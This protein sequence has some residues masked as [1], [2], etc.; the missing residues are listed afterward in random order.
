MFFGSLAGCAAVTAT[1]LMVTVWLVC[2][3]ENMPSSNL[4]SS[5]GTLSRCAAIAVAFTVILSLAI[6]IAEPPMV[7]EREPPVPSPKN[8]WS[9][10]P[11]T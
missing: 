4:T 2:L 3:L 8:T 10:S 11:C 7:A 5:A 6:S 9:V 1:S